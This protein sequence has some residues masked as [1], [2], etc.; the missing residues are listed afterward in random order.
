M[1]EQLYLLDSYL[2]SC[3]TEIIDIIN[4]NGCFSL[5]FDKTPF[6]S[7][8]GGQSSDN[9]FVES[10]VITEAFEKNGVIY[11]RIAEKYCPF[12]AGDLVLV[13]VDSDSRIEKMR[14]HTGEHIVSGIAHN[15]F[16]VENV[17]FHMDDNMI[18]TVDFDK[19]LDKSQLHLLE[20]EANKCVMKNLRVSADIY[21]VDD[22]AALNYRSK[23]DFDK[24]VRIVEI[25]KTDRC[26]CCAPHLKN[27]GEVGFIKILSSASHRG[28]VRITLI[29]GETAYSELEKRYNQIMKISAMLCSEYDKADIA[30]ADLIEANK[31]LRYEK[32]MLNN[33]LLDY[34]SSTI[35]SDEII[36]RFFD[37]LSMDELR[38]INNNLKSKCKLSLLFSGNDSSGFS[39]SFMAESLSLDRLVRD[40]NNSLGGRGGG[41]G[42]LV[43]GKVSSFKEQI[44]KYLNEMKVENYEN[45]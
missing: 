12:S 15:L 37:G 7:G 32:D 38:Y 8:G 17:G 27:T 36:I 29:C 43:Q 21:S 26:A 45:A 34:I 2:F 11:H 40:F 24:D 20:V 39:Y 18:M 44:Y 33:K 10:I 6:F 13:S 42:G 28:G 23:L 41:R 35:E 22:A 3:K 19:Y 31:N 14:A 16:G 9:G 5:V 25:E 30:V 4:E 1:T